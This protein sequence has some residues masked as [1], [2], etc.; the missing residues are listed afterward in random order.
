MEQI[1]AASDLDW[2]IT[3]PPR[4][5]DGKHTGRFRVEVGKLPKNG[6]SISRTDVAHFLLQAVDDR[7]YVRTIAGV[8]Y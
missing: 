4:F 6:F 5:T 2:T 3:R 1:V 8:C 7:T